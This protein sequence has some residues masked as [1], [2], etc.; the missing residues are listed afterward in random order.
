METSW[1]AAR[2]ELRNLPPTT[3]APFEQL[4]LWGIDIRG[5]I[6]VPRH[7]GKTVTVCVTRA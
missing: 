4:T 3:P 7:R 5:R 2:D 6:S 1:R